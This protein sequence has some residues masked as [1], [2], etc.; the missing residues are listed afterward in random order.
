[1]Q[2][3]LCVALTRGDYWSPFNRR[4]S[5]LLSGFI[6][7]SVVCGSLVTAHPCYYPNG[8]VTPN[9]IPCS[10]GEE[11]SMCC[12]AGSYCLS[13]Q[14][15]QLPDNEVWTTDGLN[16][17]YARGSCTLESWNSTNCPLFCNDPRYDQVGTGAYVV[18]CP[19]PADDLFYCGLSTR[20]PANCTIGVNVFSLGE[21]FDLI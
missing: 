7:A 1:M 12:L 8:T 5:L 16:T 3:F 6:V 21:F 15:C 9:D 2:V 19:S 13:N 14:L 20:S 11:V 17:P 4:M 18:E 10:D